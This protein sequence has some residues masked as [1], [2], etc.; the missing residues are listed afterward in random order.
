MMFQDERGVADV[1][2]ATL[3]Y[4]EVT[5]APLTSGLLRRGAVRFTVTPSAFVDHLERM[6]QAQAAPR[7]LSTIDLEQ[8]GRHL[9]LTFD[10]GGRSAMRAAAELERRGWRGHFFLITNRIGERT[11][12][13]PGDVRELHAR[14]HLV[15]SHTHTHP[16]IMRELPVDRIRAEWRESVDR[17]EQLLGA[18]CLAGAVPGGHTSAV[19]EEEA[20]NAGLRF[21]FT[22][23]PTTRPRRLGDTWVLGRLLVRRST[24][25]ETIAALAAFRGWHVASLTRRGKDVVRQGMPWLFRVWVRRMAREAGSDA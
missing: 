14:G 25:P 5:E 2:L 10:D 9:L 17:L 11:F 3:G 21:V 4:H 16:D 22:C 13:Q 23:M 12:L 1:R 8:P 19:V 20:M 24:S 7:L 6:A 15:G 18:R